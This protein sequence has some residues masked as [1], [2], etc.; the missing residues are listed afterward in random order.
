MASVGNKD[1]IKP[2]KLR[3]KLVPK[4]QK[5]VLWRINPKQ[6]DY[7]KLNDIDTFSSN[8]NVT[9]FNLS[10][11]DILYAVASGS[12]RYKGLLGIWEIQSYPFISELKGQE[13]WHPPYDKERQKMQYRVVAKRIKDLANDNG[14]K[15]QSIMG[16]QKSIP[17]PSLLNSDKIIAITKMIEGF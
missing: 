8:Y 6:C 11:G 15:I 7:S 9:K 3:I 2:A 5:H 1:D 17:R 12:Q 10:K 14:E 16:S 4:V 13:C